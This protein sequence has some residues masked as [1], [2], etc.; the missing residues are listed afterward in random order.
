MNQYSVNDIYLLNE[1]VDI[2]FIVSNGYTIGMWLDHESNTLKVLDPKSITED[3][4][5]N[6]LNKI[7]LV[8]SPKTFFE[9]MKKLIFDEPFKKVPLY[10][11]KP[12]NFEIIVKWRLQIGK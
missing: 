8:L 2:R 1:M 12:P 4:I 6:Y 7:I 9:E 11:N 10:V 5:Q 3:N